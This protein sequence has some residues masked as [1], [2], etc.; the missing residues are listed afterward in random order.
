[1]MSDW[2]AEETNTHQD[3][4]IAH[5]RSTT[6]LGY[7]ERDEALHLVLDIGFIW[8]IYVNGE[9]GLVPQRL[10]ITDLELEKQV[11][12]ELLADLDL[13][14]TD[15]GRDRQQLA[16]FTRAPVN[17]L[18]TEVA[19]YAQGERRRVLVDGEEASLAIDSSLA[20]NEMCVHVV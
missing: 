3:H 5:V 14:H 18:V 10:A 19:F 13:L 12:A 7:F 15:D 2:S 17:C 4:V 20:T 11:E 16:H 6:I 1:M 8:T 9:M